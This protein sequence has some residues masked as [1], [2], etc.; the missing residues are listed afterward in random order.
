MESILIGLLLCIGIAVSYFTAGHLAYSVGNKIPK[1][2]GFFSN[3]P[4]KGSVAFIGYSAIVLGIIVWLHSIS[5]T[6]AIMMMMAVAMVC[7]LSFFFQSIFVHYIRFFCQEW[8]QKK[9]WFAIVVSII[10]MLLN[11]ILPS[12]LTQNVVAILVATGALIVVSSISLQYVLIFFGMFVIWDAVI[13][14]G[15]NALIN[16]AKMFAGLN[17]PLMVTVPISISLESKPLFFLGL[18]DIIMPG[19][20]IMVSM[21]EWKKRKMLLLPVATT[22]GYFGGLAVAFFVFFITQSPQPATIYLMPAVVIFF[23]AA[24]WYKGILPE[25]CRNLKRG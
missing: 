7:C 21:R 15:T 19:L 14:F 12:W 16:T 11:L 23:F 4:W 5:A 8:V 17:M 20:M 1:L 24:A 18:G 3:D 2:T 22:V 25:L 13:I 9:W 6:V 10:V